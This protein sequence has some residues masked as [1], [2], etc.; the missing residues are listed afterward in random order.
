VSV[1]GSPWTKTDGKDFA[2]VLYSARCRE[3]LEEHTAVGVGSIL[4]GNHWHSAAEALG[5]V[6]ALLGA[7]PAGDVAMWSDAD[8]DRYGYLFAEMSNELAD[9][10]YFY[11]GFFVQDLRDLRTALNQAKGMRSRARSIVGLVILL[12]HPIGPMIAGPSSAEVAPVHYRCYDAGVA[13]Q[14]RGIHDGS[15]AAVYCRFRRAT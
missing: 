14:W 9:N 10:V 1:P 11:L 7:L 6:D 12:R 3:L 13:I 5:A 15:R 2:S 4:D 8:G